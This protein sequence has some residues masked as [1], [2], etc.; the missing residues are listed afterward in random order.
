LGHAAE[1]KEQAKRYEA[2]QKKL[3]DGYDAGDF[4]ADD[5]LQTDRVTRDMYAAVVVSIWSQMERVLTNILALYLEAEAYQYKESRL[6]KVEQFC[7]DSLAG[8]QTTVDVRDC[9]EALRAVQVVVP[10]EFDKI[11]EALKK[12]ARVDTEHCKGYNVVNAIRIMNNSFK[13][14]SG[15]YRQ[16]KGQIDKSLLARWAIVDKRN[17]ID[18][19]QIRVKE[20][21]EACNAFCRDLLSRVEEKLP[22]KRA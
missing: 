9:I 13:H 1:E 5:R 10:F 21:I 8:K 16:E 20:T 7:H 6:Q 2:W 15:R 11:K 22:K 18:Y 3:P 14:A 17:Q 12:Q 4:A 19:T